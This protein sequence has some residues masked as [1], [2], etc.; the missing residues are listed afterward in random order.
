M[1]YC[2]IDIYTNEI[3]LDGHDLET[4][5]DWVINQVEPLSD[6]KRIYRTWHEVDGTI[7]DIGSRVYKICHSDRYN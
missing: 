4:C 7:Y 2:V 5:V 1:N 6:G 3:V